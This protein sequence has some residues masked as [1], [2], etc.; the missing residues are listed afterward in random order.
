MHVWSLLPSVTFSDI[1][2]VCSAV[3]AQ[4]YELVRGTK[5][6]GLTFLWAFLSTTL[7]NDMQW[8][9]MDGTQVDQGKNGMA[10]PLRGLATMT[11]GEW[12]MAGQ[13]QA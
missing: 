6:P 13:E 2:L 7:K 1:L 9:V 10:H 11:Q 5:G 3:K 8:N 12:V 4:Q